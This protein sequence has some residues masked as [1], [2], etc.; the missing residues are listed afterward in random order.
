MSRS[1]W[2]LLSGAA[3][4]PPPICACLQ[5]VFELFNRAYAELE[6]SASPHFQLCMSILETVAKVGAARTF[7]A[8]ST[9]CASQTG[10]TD[11]EDSSECAVAEAC[12]GEVLA[13]HPGSPRRQGAGVQP[14]QHSAGRNQVGWWSG[15]QAPSAASAAWLSH[16]LPG[17]PLR[18]EGRSARPACPVTDGCYALSAAGT[19]P[20][21]W[22]APC[23]SCC[24][25]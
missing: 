23:W 2:C 13:A 12:T 6:D 4:Q 7:E 20:R 10:A 14:V 1:A 22:R 5:L 15:L 8:G 24:G 19:M 3:D 17:A 25:A 9:C 21:R 11:G 16:G 18:L